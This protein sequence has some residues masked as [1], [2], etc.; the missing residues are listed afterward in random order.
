[1][2]RPTVLWVT[3]SGCA[4]ASLPACGDDITTDNTP[5]IAVP[6]A[7]FAVVNSDFVST[8][9]SLLDQATGQVTNGDCI[10]SGTRAPG[11]TLA[12]SGDVVLPSQAQPGNRVVTIDRGNAALTWIDPATCTPERQLDV[13]T[14]FDA[15]P[16]DVIGVSSTKAYVP[17]Y[18]H[19]P[20][21][22]ADPADFDDGE[23]LLIIDPSI[24]AITGRIDLSS[25]AVQIPGTLIQARPD[26]GLL[27]G[28]TLYV[29]LQNLDADFTAASQG[30]IVAVDTTTDRVTRT[31][32]VTGLKN[33]SRLSYVEATQVLVVACS[34]A[35]SDADQVAGSGAVSFDLSGASPVEIDR[36]TAAPLGGRAIGTYVGDANDGALGF[37]VTFGDFA[38]ATL[39]DQFWAVDTASH[40]AT[41]LADASDSF[42]FGGVLVD[43]DHDRVYLTDANAATPRVQIYHYATTTPPVLESSVDTNPSLGLPP[44]EIAAY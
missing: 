32:D 25:Y 29:V 21:P 36:Q 43:P 41:K 33:C 12:L 23:D 39:T 27:V 37:A 2:V 19:N 31:I 22:T 5:A 18:K 17:R 30:R 35:F 44:R 3:L 26:R 14:G 34:G 1:M 24:P 6:P 38:P 4:L 20:A 8:S 13:S 15:N 16:H 40:T 11:A 7:G 42:T 10:D 9:V 28:T